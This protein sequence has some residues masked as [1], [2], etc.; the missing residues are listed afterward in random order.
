M[1]SASLGSF[2]LISL[3]ICKFH[4]RLQ[5]KHQHIHHHSCNDLNLSSISLAS[6][7]SKPILLHATDSNTDAPISLPEGA[8]SV[9]NFEEFMEKDWSVLDTDQSSSAEEFNKHIDRIISAGKIKETSRVLVSVGSEGF[10]DRLVDSSPCK[11]LLVVH[12]SLLM[13]AGIKEKYDQVKCW[14]GEIIYVPETW[15]PLDVVF[16]YFLP[17]L[18]FKLDNILG[19]LAKKCSPG[20]FSV[21]LNI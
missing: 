14:Q 1:N 20:K 4:P 17:A 9:I 15:A 21:S 2:H 13:L 10:V 8:V 18:P 16:L 6:S 12:D 3:P 11:F 7:L 5:I 19:S